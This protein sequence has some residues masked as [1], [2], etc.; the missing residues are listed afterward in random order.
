MRRIL[1]LMCLAV[2]GML[3]G[4]VHATAPTEFQAV[5]SQPYALGAGDR[6]RVIVFGQDSLSNSFSVD[7]SGHIAMPLIGLVPAAGRSPAQLATEIEGRLRA[8][9][10]REPRVSVEIEAYRP[11]FVLGEVTTSGQYPYVNGMTVETAVAIAGGYT[12]RASR[13]H[14]ELT[15]TQDGR[16]VTA[17]VPMAQ[18][19][20]PGDTIMVRERFF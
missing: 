16:T 6:V 19:V 1:L 17:D 18:P 10:V 15:R 14:A 8:G 7:S 20:R 12:P 4:C 11:F 9:Y 3:Q 5:A 2:A 13:D